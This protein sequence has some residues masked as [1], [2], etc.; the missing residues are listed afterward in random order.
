M[1]ITVRAFKYIKTSVDKKNKFRKMTSMQ[2]V[3]I[4]VQQEKSCSCRI[5]IFVISLFGCPPW[6][7]GT[8]A[9]FAHPLHATGIGAVE[10]HANM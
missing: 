5:L 6:M 4:T 7:H 10:S 3:L 1:I 9:L 2:H 8:I